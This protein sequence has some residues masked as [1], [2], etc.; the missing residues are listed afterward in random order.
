MA[1]GLLAWWFT[2]RLGHQRTLLIV[3]IGQGLAMLLFTVTKNAWS[4]FLV[5]ALFGFTYGTGS[6][7]RMSMIPPLFG[8]RS[9]GTMLGCTTFAW[10][11]GGLVGPYFAGYVHDV[12]EQYAFAFLAG[13]ILCAIGALSVHLWG[14]HKREPGLLDETA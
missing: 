8:L 5:I 2:K 3:L 1:G 4:F 6:P 11:I 14:S 10:S 13:G 7:V 9:I 12:T